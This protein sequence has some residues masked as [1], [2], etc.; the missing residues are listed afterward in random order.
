MIENLENNQ[1]TASENMES[2]EKSFVAEQEQR[3]YAPQTEVKNFAAYGGFWRRIASHVLDTW[4]TVVVSILFYIYILTYFGI[5]QISTI[6]GDI[7]SSFAEF[8]IPIIAIVLVWLVNIGV[9]IYFYFKDGQTLGYRI[10]G[11]KI[12]SEKTGEKPTTGELW[13]RFGMKFVFSSFLYIPFV[14]LFAMFIFYP[15]WGIMLAVDKRKQGLHEKLSGTLVVMEKVSRT[16]VVWFVNLV[17]FTIA[18]FG[19]LAGIL[20]IAID[21]QKQVDR[22]VESQQKMMEQQKMIQ[23]VLDRDL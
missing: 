20:L 7:G 18:L 4:P 15:V 19:I 17:P 2:G 21:P 12:I 8:L 22:A 6:G 11:M 3:E 1:N 23:D 9:N 14:N 5:S 10:L 13:G 16:W